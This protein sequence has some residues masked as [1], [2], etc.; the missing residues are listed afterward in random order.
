MRLVHPLGREILQN[1]AK[2]NFTRNSQRSAF[3]ER[4]EGSGFYYGT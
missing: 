1:L 3:N 2:E 4:G